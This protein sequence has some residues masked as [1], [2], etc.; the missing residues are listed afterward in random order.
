MRLRYLSPASSL[1][2]SNNHLLPSALVHFLPS[3]LHL[4]PLYFI[5]THCPLHIHLSSLPSPSLNL[6]FSLS[7]SSLLHPFFPSFFTPALSPSPSHLIACA[8]LNFFPLHM[9]RKTNCRSV[10]KTSLDND[11]SKGL[12]VPCEVLALYTATVNPLYQCNGH[13]RG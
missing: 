7:S 1:I 10:L 2:P 3:P 12:T 13:V 9:Q 8:Q 4:L 5:S 11:N 6:S